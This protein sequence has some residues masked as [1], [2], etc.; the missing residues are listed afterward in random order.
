MITVISG[1][2]QK[3][4]LITEKYFIICRQRIGKKKLKKEWRNSG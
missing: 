1:T 4:D 3:T 2:G